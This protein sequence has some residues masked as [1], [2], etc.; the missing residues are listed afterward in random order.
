VHVLNFASKYDK[1]KFAILDID[2]VG[3]QNLDRLDLDLK[4][5]AIPSFYLYRDGYLCDTLVS[6]SHIKLESF[7]E[8]NY[9]K[10]KEKI[11]E[12]RDD[13]LLA[14]DEAEKLKVFKCSLCSQFGHKTA[15]CGLSDKNKIVK[16]N[17]SN[18]K[19]NSIIEKA[20]SGKIL[21]NKKQITIVVNE[22]KKSPTE[23]LA[24]TYPQQFDNLT[25]KSATNLNSNNNNKTFNSTSFI[26]NSKHSK[27]NSDSG[28]LNLLEINSKKN[29]NLRN[30]N[31]KSSSLNYDNSTIDLRET[32]SKS[33]NSRES[34]DTKDLKISDD[35]SKDLLDK[36]SK[37]EALTKKQKEEIV[38]LKEKLEQLSNEN[39][40]L[41][42]QNR[43][44]Y[45]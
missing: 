42:S 36:I 5:G 7:I 28:S 39:K 13:Q 30:S 31:A 33:T 14:L 2:Y 44:S 27:L 12:K 41:K 20:I 11:N 40:I 19:T 4:L 35:S 6:S 18:E 45:Y 22:K 10:D 9:I 8:T 21:V 43:N 29:K 15:Q 38:M 26:S 34:K 16:S 23:R 25:S 37:L 24:I 1:I 17:I 32:K 3:Q